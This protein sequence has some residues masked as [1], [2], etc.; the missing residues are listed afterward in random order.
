MSVYFGQV[1]T[2]TVSGNTRM[3]VGNLAVIGD[4]LYYINGEAEYIVKVY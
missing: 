3:H 2:T 4:E 1:L